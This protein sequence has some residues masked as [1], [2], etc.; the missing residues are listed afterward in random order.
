MPFQLIR[1]RKGNVIGMAGRTPGWNISSIHP[2]VSDKLQGRPK[3]SVLCFFF[4]SKRKLFMWPCMFFFFRKL[5]S[6]SQE[7]VT[8]RFKTLATYLDGWLVGKSF[9]MT[10]KAFGSQPVGVK[11]HGSKFN[12]RMAASQCDNLFS[13]IAVKPSQ[14]GLC[15]RRGEDNLM[16]SQRKC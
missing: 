7:D 12:G 14:H 3:L 11:W 4:W 2:R 15:G 1:G 8:T 10:A 9:G 5:T 13:A 16:D 6:C